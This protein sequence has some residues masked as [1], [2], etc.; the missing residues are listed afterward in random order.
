MDVC[1]GEHETIGFKQF[2]TIME[3]VSSEMFICVF[4]LIRA[5]L[6]DYIALRRYERKKDEPMC[7]ST[8]P[9][10]KRFASP[11]ILSKFGPVSDVI[12]ERKM[13]SGSVGR[14]NIGPILDFTVRSPREDEEDTGEESKVDQLLHHKVPVSKFKPGLR[15]AKIDTSGMVTLQQ[16]YKLEAP[17]S[18]VDSP[19]NGVAVRMPNSNVKGRDVLNSPSV[20]FRGRS[21][22]DEEGICFCECGRAILEM[23]KYCDK[24]IEKKFVVKTEGDLY[25][26]KNATAIKFWFVLE[27][28]SLYSKYIYNILYIIGYES[29]EQNKHIKMYN[30]HGLFVRE[31][32]E[33]VLE[34]KVYYPFTLSQRKKG[35]TFYAASKEDREMW[36]EA[37][38]KAIGYANIFDYYDIQVYI[39]INIYIYIYRED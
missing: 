17:G 31:E 10:S 39:F 15:P 29:E 8:P 37:I 13:R 6:P 9:M 36:S 38:K 11:K 14:I 18:Y 5:Q 33:E 27:G 22:D 24:C 30:I 26:K 3:T 12:R 19:I 7:P 23:G 4:N 32:L 35:R 16:K 21:H 1:L 34:K 2:E 20:L 25:R 28:K